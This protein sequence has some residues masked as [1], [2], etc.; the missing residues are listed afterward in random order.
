M[1]PLT[2]IYFARKALGFLD[3][4]VILGSVFPDIIVITGL[5]WHLCHTRGWVF[6]QHFQKED[7][8]LR[9]FSLGVITHGIEPKGLDYYSDKQYM[10]FEKGY[11]FE[12]AR[13]L[14]DS[15]VDACYLPVADGWWKAHNFV[16]MGVELYIYEK[17]PELLTLLRQAHANTAL[18][19]QLTRSFSP[20][21][22]K[23]ELSLQK[24]FAIFR[25]AAAEPF[26]LQRMA[27]RYQRQVF[28]RYNITSINLPKCREII[29][30]SKKLIV[31]DIEEFFQNVKRMMSPTWKEICDKG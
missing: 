29:L 22:N 21:L 13:P 5:D 6:W 17:Q 16:E 1:Y 11:C 8:D 26:D 12:K 28:Y 4:A 20:L 30:R 2:H 19:R 3:D 14:V 27:M 23:S 10:D 15:V 24:A 25:N 31:P 9:N 7:K 18:V